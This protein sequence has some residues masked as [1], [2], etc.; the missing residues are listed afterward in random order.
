MCMSSI[1][2]N[3]MCMYF[4]MQAFVCDVFI[5][6]LAPTICCI[7]TS[8]SKSIPLLVLYVK[9]S[10]QYMALMLIKHLA[11][12]RAFFVVCVVLKT[13]VVFNDIMN[14]LCYIIILFFTG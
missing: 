6:R 2:A 10:T 8:N 1:V 12:P 11:L 9:Q 13:S 14:N 5:L 7:L 3:A 4:F